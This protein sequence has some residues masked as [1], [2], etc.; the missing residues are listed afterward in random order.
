[1]PPVPCELCGTLSELDD[2][3]DELPV[4]P[5][6]LLELSPPEDELSP[7]ELLLELDEV[8]SS[9]AEVLSEEE[10]AIRR[11]EE[12]SAAAAK[13]DT[14][15]VALLSMGVARPRVPRELCHEGLRELAFKEELGRSE[16]QPARSL[17]FARSF[18]RTRLPQTGHGQMAGFSGERVRRK[19]GTIA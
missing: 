19:A 17:A 11:E 5:D 14:S 6:E 13:R 15:R 1:M 10:Q 16:G 2:E 9:S 3:L 4:E 12:S 18:G 7:P 8:S